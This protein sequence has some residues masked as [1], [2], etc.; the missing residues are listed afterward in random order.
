M[1]WFDVNAEWIKTDD[2]QWRKLI[3]ATTSH[4]VE[5]REQPDGYVYVSGIIDTNDYDDDEK[6]SIITAYYSSMEEFKESYPEEEINGILAECIF[7]QT[8][9]IE[10]TCFGLF[11][12]EEEA[13]TRALE[14]IAKQ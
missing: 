10:L 14:Y 12:T 9:E 5:V 2:L 3:N 11:E 4:L 1:N 7:E 6:E 8:H 13:E